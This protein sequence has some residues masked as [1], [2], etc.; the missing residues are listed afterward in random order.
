[1]IVSSN[2]IGRNR[3]AGAGYSLVELMV[4]VALGLIILAG[5]LQAFNSNSGTGKTNAR[6]AEVQANGRYSIDFLR[7]ELQHA[8]FLSMVNGPVQPPKDDLAPVRTTDYGCGV[9]FAAKLEERI[10]GV[11]D[12]NAGL[13]C[14]PNADY[15]RGDILVL[16]RA[17]LSPVGTAAA[18]AWTRC[19]DAIDNGEV[20]AANKMYV[21]TEFM[22]AYV[23]VGTTPPLNLQPPFT[24]YPVCVDVYYISPCS[25]TNVACDNAAADQIPSLKRMSLGTGPAMTSQL[26]AAGI[27]NMQIQYGVT[28][29]AAVQF[30]DAGSITAE[31]WPNVVAVRLWLLARSSD[32]E[33][34][35][36][37]NTSTYAMGNQNPTMNDNFVRQLMPLV[38]SLRK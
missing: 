9:G 14:I 6:F 35:G 21:R 3:L 32:P 13:S 15:A 19:Q 10:F 7:K 22:Q 30:M 5:M 25:N 8:G 23:F 17:A 11:D 4:A 29:G 16:R 2:R 24:D 33:Y 18:T 31:N 20:L 38:V 26:I 34:N 37:T 12:T 28:L 36:F 1:M 27:E